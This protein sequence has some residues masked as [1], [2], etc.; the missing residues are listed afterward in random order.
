MQESVN[1]PPGAASNKYK[2]YLRPAYKSNELLIEI[3]TGVENENFFYELTD[4]IKD[5][6]AEILSTEDLFMNDEV[7]YKF[8]SDLGNFELSKDIWDNA[9]IMACNNQNCILA[10]NNLFQKDIRFMKV[11]V[12]FNNYK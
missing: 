1:T 2:Y 8:N 6:N 3:F 7:L 10:I 11:E 12:D 4:A 9:F 5:I